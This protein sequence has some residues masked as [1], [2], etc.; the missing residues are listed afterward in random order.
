[1]ARVL[2]VIARFLGRPIGPQDGKANVP[3]PLICEVE[4]VAHVELQD[5]E[6]SSQILQRPNDGVLRLDR[7][8]LP[9]LIVGEVRLESVA[10]LAGEL[11]VRLL[12]YFG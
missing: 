9:E 3:S 1:M 8:P 4:R 6:P 2:G 7:R 11:T 10:H 12:V 5:A